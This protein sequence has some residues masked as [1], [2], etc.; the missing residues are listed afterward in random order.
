MRVAIVRQRYNAQ[1][2]AERFIERALAALARQGLAVTV[3]ARWLPSLI[4]IARPVRSPVPAAW[5]V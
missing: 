5:I 2:G 1:G 3:L 4:V